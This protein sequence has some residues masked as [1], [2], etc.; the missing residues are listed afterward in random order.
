MKRFM[1]ILLFVLAA[2]QFTTVLAQSQSVAPGD[3]LV[4][5]GIPA[6]PA[7]MAEEIN[8]YT[9]F[10]YAALSNWHP[11]RREMLIGTRFGDTNQIH[12][13]KF[14]GGARTH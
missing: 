3:N 9:E 12:L 8:R 13:V 11:T 6:I 1:T 14:P 4:V 10:R 5:E 2:A 7:A